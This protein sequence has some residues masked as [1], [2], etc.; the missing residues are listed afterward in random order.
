MEKCIFEQRERAKENA[1]WL[2]RSLCDFYHLLTHN[3]RRYML[4]HQKHQQTQVYK[5][6]GCVLCVFC[7]YWN[8]LDFSGQ[9]ELNSC[10]L[11]NKLE[12]LS[13]ASFYRAYLQNLFA[14][15]DGSLRNWM[16]PWSCYLLCFSWANDHCICYWIGESWKISDSLYD[17]SRLSQI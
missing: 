15:L 16:T 9:N 3:S 4:L 14:Y 1:I 2:H 6:V 12:N 5:I 11:W 13:W 10:L 7:Q 17:L 8:S